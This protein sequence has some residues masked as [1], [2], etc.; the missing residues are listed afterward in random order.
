MTN[1]RRPN[2]SLGR[3]ESWLKR[4]EPTKR[5]P[6]PTHRLIKDSPT[7]LHYKG[8]LIETPAGAIAEA[9]HYLRPPRCSRDNVGRYHL[10]DLD[11]SGRRRRRGCLV[12]LRSRSLVKLHSGLLPLRFHPR[13]PP[14]R[15][16]PSSLGGSGAGFHLRKK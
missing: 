5:L 8:A 9:G 14:L 3:T 10:L 16:P 7:P 6:R 13:S 1:T 11:S 12:T 4:V 15:S 2:T